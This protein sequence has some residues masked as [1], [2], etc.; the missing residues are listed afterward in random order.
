MPTTG[1]MLEEISGIAS[2]TVEFLEKSHGV[3]YQFVVIA[4]GDAAFALCHSPI[5]TTEV[6]NL[7][8]KCIEQIELATTIKPPSE[9]Q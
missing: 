4:Q 7:L 9:L 2:S 3:N 1:E 5:D 6:L 8:R